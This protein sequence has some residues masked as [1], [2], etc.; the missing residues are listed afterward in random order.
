[1][2]RRFV[3]HCRP[4]IKE[5]LDRLRERMGT[6]PPRSWVILALNEWIGLP[7]GVGDLDDEPTE[8]KPARKKPPAVR[9]R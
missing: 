1:V 8:I 3:W 4:E 6:I 7:A 2:T 5:H 9:T